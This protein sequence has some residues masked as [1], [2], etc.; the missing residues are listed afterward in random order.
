MSDQ[1]VDISRHFPKAFKAERKGRNALIMYDLGEDTIRRFDGKEARWE[2][3]YRWLS[4]D[5][6]DEAACVKG[7]ENTYWR[8][9][10]WDENASLFDNFNVV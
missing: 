8:D 6:D 4:C 9:D 3:N 2:L 1:V 7:S 10:E 5:N